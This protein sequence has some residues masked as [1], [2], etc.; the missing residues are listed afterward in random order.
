MPTME[1]DVA[2][3]GGGPA[4]LMAAEVL[5][6]AGLGV[7]LFDAMPSVGRKFLLAGKGGMNLTHAEALPQFLQRY[8][9]RTEALQALLETFGPQQVR[10]WAAGLGISTFVGSSHRVFPTDMKA[11]PLLR[12]WLQRLR[13]PPAG[14]PPVQFHMRHRWLAWDGEAS[15]QSPDTLVFQ[16]PG[17]L[18]RV[19]ARAVV[20]ALGG[21]SWARLGSDGAWV[22]P[23]LSA[24]VPVAP[25]LPSNCG[26][27]VA[28]SAVHGVVAGWSP[29]FSS[30]F[31][32]QPFKSV[33]IRVDGPGVVFQRRGEFVA[34]Q[35]GVEGSLIYA[36]SALLRDAI[37]R[38]GQA[39]FALDLLPDHSLDQVL[40][41]LRHPRG[42]RSLSAHLKSRL[43][44]D[45]IKMALLNECLP[46][47]SMQKPELLAQAIK[48]LPIVVNAPRPIDEAIS[49]AGGVPFEALDP[50]LML[51]QLP[52]VFCAGEMLDW[53]AP[54]GGYLLTAC[55]ASGEAA[56]RG[57]QA[58]LAASGSAP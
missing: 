55:L 31:A 37:A 10:E 29:H 47:D 3:V 30:R 53:E 12:A 36:A 24:G 6:A 23:F 17:G 56:G 57:A 40:A 27:D 41:Q 11:A 46:R 15:Q 35:G 9:A 26:F 22:P 42:S 33:A 45:G 58:W 20:F 48:G 49:S 8:G 43:G 18:Q 38:K 50:G 19:R 16:T 51:T 44:L 34:T 1:V 7:H 54:T 14:G 25:L 4:G 5:S 32:G 39:A 2:V 28:G 52:G 21:A 13:H